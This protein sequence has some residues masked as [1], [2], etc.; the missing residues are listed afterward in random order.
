MGPTFSV[1]ILVGNPPNQKKW[2]ERD[3]PPTIPQL[4]I[5]HPNKPTV[6]EHLYSTP[7]FATFRGHQKPNPRPDAPRRTARCSS[8]SATKAPSVE[9]TCLGSRSVSVGSSPRGKP[10][11][12]FLSGF[13]FFGAGKGERNALGLKRGGEKRD[14]PWRWKGSKK[15]ERVEV[16]WGVQPLNHNKTNM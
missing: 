7:L 10:P 4:H 5:S 6:W 1:R 9:E 2:R 12:F 11:R 16:K 15:V 8:D 13:S 3:N 14:G